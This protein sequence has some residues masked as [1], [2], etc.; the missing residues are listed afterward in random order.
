MTGLEKTH[1]EETNRQTDMATTTPTGPRAELVKIM[2]G[3]L[4][5]KFLFSPTLLCKFL[6][7]LFRALYQFPEFQ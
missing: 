3:F 4:N 6:L 2:L 5:V 1:G 7:Y